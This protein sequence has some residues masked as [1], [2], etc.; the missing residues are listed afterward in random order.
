MKLFVTLL[1]VITLSG[2]VAGAPTLTAEQ[3]RKLSSIKVYKIGQQPDYQHQEI[4][5]ISAADCSGQ[6]GTRLYGDEKKALDTLIIKAA[7]LNAIAVKEVSC[8]G[9]PLINNCWAAMVCEGTAISKE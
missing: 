3:S 5:K 1:S 7:S 9:A 6:P 2:C 4:A 8:N